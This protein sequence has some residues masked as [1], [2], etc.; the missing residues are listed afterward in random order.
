MLESGERENIFKDSS[1]FIYSPTQ[2]K[3]RNNEKKDKAIK[4]TNSTAYK[5]DIATQQQ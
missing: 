5:K 4:T 1:M 3:K 2:Q